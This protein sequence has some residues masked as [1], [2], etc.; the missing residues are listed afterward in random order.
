MKRNRISALWRPALG[1]VIL[2]VILFVSQVALTGSTGN[3][4]NPAFVAPV[5][6]AGGLMATGIESVVARTSLVWGTIAGM[7]CIMVVLAVLTVIANLAILTT[8][9][10]RS[11]APM[12]GLVAAF[13]AA[14][15]GG[16]VAIERRLDL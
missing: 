8:L 14:Y 16:R 9:S 11:F 5:I 4:L 10:W 2:Y 12:V 7:C 13:S 6:I 15:A 1:A 3:L